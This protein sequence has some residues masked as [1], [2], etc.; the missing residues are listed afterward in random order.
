MLNCSMMN[1]QRCILNKMSHKLLQKQIT[2]LTWVIILIIGGL[3]NIA[4][5][6]YNGGKMPV[7]GIG[8]YA[9]DSH[10]GYTDFDEVRIPHLTDIIPAF[11]RIWSFGD[12][13]IILSSG[14]IVY[15]FIEVMRLFLKGGKSG[16]R[17][18]N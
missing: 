9:S 11:G 14:F 16:M 13:I 17:K 5:I 1:G 15:Y 4:A 7:L 2:L 3:A 12:V 8:Y 18:S 6:S 10:F